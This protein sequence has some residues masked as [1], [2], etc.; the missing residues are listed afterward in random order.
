MYE[1]FFDFEKNPQKKT[2][3]RQKVRGISF[4]LPNFTV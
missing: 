4:L 1:G 2:I 3:F